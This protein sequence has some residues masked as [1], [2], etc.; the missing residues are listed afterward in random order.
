[1]KHLLKNISVNFNKDE[2]VEEGEKNLEVYVKYKLS[3]YLL[4]VLLHGERKLLG[5]V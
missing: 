5:L 1:M 3:K 2:E 4:I